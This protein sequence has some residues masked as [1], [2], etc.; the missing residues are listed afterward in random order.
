M[1]ANYLD[2]FPSSLRLPSICIW[3]FTKSVGLAMNCAIAPADKPLNAAFLVN[4]QTCVHMYLCHQLKIISLSQYYHQIHYTTF[5][6]NCL[7]L[8]NEQN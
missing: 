8:E 6:H 7:F 2:G 4:K 5:H 1:A 3:T